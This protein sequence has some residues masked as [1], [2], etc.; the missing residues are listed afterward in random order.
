MIRR[1]AVLAA[2][3][4]AAA[5]ARA[6]ITTLDLRPTPLPVRPDDWIAPGLR[7]EV[8]IRW[9][10]RV[11]P[12]APEWTPR[13]PNP[14]AAGA[15]F[16]WDA[17]IAGLVEPPPAAD[18][19]PRLV[20]AVVHPTVD[21]AM[22]WPGVRDRPAVAAAMQG[23]SILN[24]EKTGERWVI[25]DG[26]FQS[27]RLDADTLCRWQG[28]AATAPAVQGILAPQGGCA[29]P[30]G[31]LL[32]SEG[33]P[34]VWLDRLR[35]LDPRW[36]E[37]AGYGWAVEFDPLDPGS[38]PVKRS[39]LGRIGAVATLALQA[40]EGRAVVLMADGRPGGFLYRFVS[41]KPAS[42]PDALD[43]GR[44]SVARL[45]GETLR[46][47][48]LPAGAATDPASAA[49]ALGASRLDAPFGLARDPRSA[50]VLLACRGD[51]RVAGQVLD[52]QGDPAAAQW[53]S[54]VLFVAGEVAQGGRYGRDQPPGALPRNP[55]TVAVDARG[56][57][58]IG[59]D[60]GGQVGQQ[61]DAV[62]A[63]DLDG[64]GRGVVLPA[65]AA[66][67]AA[68]IGGAVPT[69]GAET[70][71]AMVRHPGAA[72]GASYANPA[73]RWPAF[74]AAL[75]PRTTLVALSRGGAPVGG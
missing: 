6:Q 19:V 57:A 33:D 74:D 28:P 17:R 56:R 40:S 71:L 61:A 52:L 24:L 65:Y 67:R 51:A 58:W 36:T 15:Q 49:Q 10:D 30:W 43:D 59:T 73:T 31:S 4:L 37:A 2:A 53:E 41:A 23:A 38:V 22:A 39:A 42:E 25:V 45:G 70:V 20:L 26:G 13:E 64:P 54:R 63:C 3:A 7:R 35:G 32:L 1:R 9:G 69:P 75:P 46:W 11:L 62:F 47:E 50:R 34:T 66:P 5:P 12:D 29:T 18:G 21:P 44:L 16:G 14:Q 60:Q 8:L 72:P 55:A 27:R 68:A 48:A